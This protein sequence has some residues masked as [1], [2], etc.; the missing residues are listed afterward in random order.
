MAKSNKTNDLYVFFR[1]DGKAVERI[2]AGKR[3]TIGS[4]YGSDITVGGAGVPDKV[5]LLE[6]TGSGAHTLMLG[7]W[8]NGTFK[9]DDNKAESTI[10]NILSLGILKRTGDAYPYELTPGVKIELR[11]GD[12]SI[13]FG[14]LDTPGVERPARLF[15][16]PFISTKDYLFLALIIASVLIHISIVK[17]L[18]TI[19]IKKE[20]TLE[21]I[22]KLDPRFARLILTPRQKAVKAPTELKVEEEVEEEVEEKKE[23][24]VKEAKPKREQT[25]EQQE[26]AKRVKNKGLLGVIGA[27]GGLLGDIARDEVWRDIDSLIADTIMDSGDDFGDLFGTSEVTSAEGLVVAEGP[28]Q[29]SQEDIIKEKGEKASFK[30]DKKKKSADKRGRASEVHQVVKRY[31]GGLKY[32]YNNALRRTPT[33]KG[34]VTVRMVISADGKVKKATIDSTSLGSPRLEAQIIKRILLWRFKKIPGSEDFTITYTFDFS[35]I[36]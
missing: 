27:K 25:P 29:R 28:T 30:K 18:G 10:K 6:K 9:R 26:V 12:T 17:Y 15:P 16:I 22:R 34:S 23:E 4:D 24:A 1:K 11:V 21:E 35:P 33:L 3:L 19:E 5:V 7:E 13:G 14:Y 20:S 32:L 8:M 2:R 36:G 31:S